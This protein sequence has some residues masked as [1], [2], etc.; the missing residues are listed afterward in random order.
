MFAARETDCP[1]TTDISGRLLRLPF[2]NNL[3]ADDVDRVVA[4]FVSSV[5]ES[6]S[7]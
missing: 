1:V 2:H 7:V 5:T 4:A 6:I 3:G